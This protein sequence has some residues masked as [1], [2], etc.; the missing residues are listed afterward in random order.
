VRFFAN[1]ARGTDPDGQPGLKSVAR[2]QAAI[3]ADESHP[4]QSIRKRSVPAQDDASAAA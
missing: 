1:A 4:Q 3:A 2:S